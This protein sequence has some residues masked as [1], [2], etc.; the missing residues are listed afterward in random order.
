[1]GEVT[2]KS[3]YQTG[4]QKGHMGQSPCHSRAG[5]SQSSESRMDSASGNDGG[6]QAK[7]L[8]TLR[9]NNDCPLPLPGLPSRLCKGLQVSGRRR[10]GEPTQRWPP[11]SPSIQGENSDG[12]EGP[13]MAMLGR[14]G[15]PCQGRSPWHSGSTGRLLSCL[16]LSR[17]SVSSGM[18][19]YG[20]DVHG[21]NGLV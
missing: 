3:T 8:C 5:G 16:S 14:W 11:Q 21:M 2:K 10:A 18:S 12:P 13:S 7:V 4:N 9:V 19:R 6:R 17:I 20:N 15:P 1:M